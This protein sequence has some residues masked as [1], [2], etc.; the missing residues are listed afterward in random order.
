MNYFPN[1]PMVSALPCFAKH[2]LYVDTKG[3]NK[4]DQKH[5]PGFPHDAPLTSTTRARAKSGYPLN[6]P[7]SGITHAIYF[8]IATKSF[9]HRWRPKKT[10]RTHLRH[11]RL[12]PEARVQCH[13]KEEEGQLHGCLFEFTCA[14][15]NHRCAQCFG[16]F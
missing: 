15:Q 2:L 13:Q 16:Y 8:G 7:V 14:L 1:D 3:K 11:E 10:P 12:A 4:I 5:S 9:Q 6:P